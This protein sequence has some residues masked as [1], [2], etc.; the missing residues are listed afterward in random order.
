[1]TKLVLHTVILAGWWS[2]WHCERQ[3]LSITEWTTRRLAKEFFSDPH[4]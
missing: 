4:I 3:Q 1:M 2:H